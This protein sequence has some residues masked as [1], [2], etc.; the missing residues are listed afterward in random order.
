M[1]V[2]ASAIGYYGNRGDEVVDES[3]PPGSGFLAEVCEDWEAATAPARDAN[4]RVVNLRTG[5]VLAES[6]GGLAKMLT[7]FRLGARRRHRQRPAVY[8]LDR[9]R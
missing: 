1:L 9:A 5:F 6:G 7:P 4:I 8:E 2:S 3:S